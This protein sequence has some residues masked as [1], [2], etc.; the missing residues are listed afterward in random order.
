MMNVWKIGPGE[1]Q[2]LPP[3][4]L[5]FNGEKIVKR[6]VAHNTKEISQY[7]AIRDEP[8][9]YVIFFMTGDLAEDASFETQ[10][11]YGSDRV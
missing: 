1:M 7:V 8:G 11:E 10:E 2:E 9:L 5:N 3:V 4:E 6:I